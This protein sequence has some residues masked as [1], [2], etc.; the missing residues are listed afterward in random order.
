MFATNLKYEEL[1]Y[2]KNPKMCYPIPE[3]LL[4]I[5]PH[6]GQSSREN[7]T[8]ASGTSPLASYNELPPVKKF[9]HPVLKFP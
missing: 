3:T 6:Y 9:N 8:P 5:R 4:K 2:L 1:S 7:A